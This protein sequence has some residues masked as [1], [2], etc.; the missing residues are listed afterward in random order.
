MI[1][2][3]TFITGIVKERES[4]VNKNQYN[5]NNACVS[6]VMIFWTILSGLCGAET[7]ERKEG[8]GLCWDFTKLQTQTETERRLP[9][10]CELWTRVT[11][12]QLHNDSCPWCLLCCC[13]FYQAFISIFNFISDQIQGIMKIFVRLLTCLILQSTICQ[14]EIA[15][16]AQCK[17]QGNLSGTIILQMTGNFTKVSGMIKN[18]SEGKHGFHIHEV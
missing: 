11:T 10:N 5:N 13:C 17:L 6:I 18:L 8:P 1:K 14:A 7:A 15:K 9:V 12:K 16:I 2:H 4:Q 3:W